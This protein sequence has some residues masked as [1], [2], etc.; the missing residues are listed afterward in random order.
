M[1]DDNKSVDHILAWMINEL[2]PNIAKQNPTGY[3]SVAAALLLI[4][5]AS[6]RHSLCQLKDKKKKSTVVLSSVQS[7]V[8]IKRIIPSEWTGVSDSSS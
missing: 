7:A 2:C 5:V 1:T 4:K 6:E 8:G 3:G